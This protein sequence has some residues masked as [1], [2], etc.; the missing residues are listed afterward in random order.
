MKGIHLDQ[1][2]FVRYPNFP[3][4]PILLK[5][6]Y[7]CVFWVTMRQYF[8]EREIARQS[9]ALAHLAA[10]F[11][12]TVSAATSDLGPATQAADN[13][14][15]KIIMRLGSFVKQC[16]LQLWIWIVVLALFFCAIYGQRM[17]AFRIT[18]MAL[19]LTFVITFQVSWRIWTK[20]MYAYWVVVIGF[21]MCTLV[22]IY[23]YQFDGFSDY[24]TKYTGIPESL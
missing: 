23:T 6:L 2:G 12:V 18:Y 20:L 14:K 22:M 10:P 16:L 11:Q 21:A 5:T 1:I 4:V 7:T 15:S 13:K 17:T 24:W 9:S 3:C 8:Y 19:F